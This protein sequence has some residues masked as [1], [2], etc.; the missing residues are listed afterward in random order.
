MTSILNGNS[1]CGTGLRGA[2]VDGMSIDIGVER[3]LN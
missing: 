3:I 1:Q 2:N